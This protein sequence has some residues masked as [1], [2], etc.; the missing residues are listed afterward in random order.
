MAKIRVLFFA[1]FHDYV[2]R[3]DR[4]LYDLIDSAMED[5]TL[6]VNVWG[7]GFPGYKNN[8]SLVQNIGCGKY[9]LV[10]T[11]LTAG[12][13]G[14]PGNCGKTILISEV[15]DCFED[16]CYSYLNYLANIT[17][18]RYASELIDMFSWE[19]M[20]EKIPLF[21][22]LAKN[23][24]FGAVQDCA[25]PWVFYPLRKPYLERDVGLILYGA[26]SGLYPLRV[27]LAEGIRSGKVGRGRSNTYLHP[28]YQIQPPN[29]TEVISAL[30][31]TYT[32]YDP[33]SN[34]TAWHRAVRDPYA[35]A[36]RRSQLCTFDAS[37]ER[38]LIRKYMEAMLSGCS[39]TADVPTDMDFP[40]GVGD[41]ILPLDAEWDV[42]TLGR[43]I[44]EY[45]ADPAD[46]ASRSLNSFIFARQH[47]TCRKK[48]DLILDLA[49]RYW[50][51]E[52]GYVFQNGFSA[53]CRSYGNSDQ[54]YHPPWCPQPPKPAASTSTKTVT[55]V[56]TA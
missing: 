34:I 11:S 52:R 27:K 1:Y 54:G 18:T 48:M 17:T 29:S 9:D 35:Q 13:V 3:M 51:G 56:V 44:D 30:Y 6:D 40:G 36:M 24:L 14:I 39:V 47:F 32:T 4:F 7:P 23:H 26:I 21:L 10:Y 5:P 41:L 42:D 15:G 19:R 25:N 8:L 50:R 46:L 33:A 53:V 55:A 45:L 38:K 2:G 49:E 20:K 28:G 31:A 22:P 43:K 12:Y 16:K 37:I